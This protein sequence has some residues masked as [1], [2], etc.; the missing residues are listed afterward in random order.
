MNLLFLV[1]NKLF[2][3]ASEH[4]GKRANFFLEEVETTR[5]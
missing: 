4:S 2:K 3:S 1:S 5:E